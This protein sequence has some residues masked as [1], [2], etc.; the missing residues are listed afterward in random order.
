MAAG[1]GDFERALGA[2]LAFDVGQV[3]MHAVELADLR[4]RPVEDLRALEV[5]GELDQRLRRDDL[6]LR[7][8][9]GGLRA[10]GI[11]AD[12]AVT[13]CIG[14]DRGG[15]H[16]GHRGNRAVEAEFAEHVVA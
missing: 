15:Q 2:L 13:A 4:L 14:A 12:E 8:R 11:G 1:R 6:D 5:V 3:E 7:A 16:T 9:P 10:A